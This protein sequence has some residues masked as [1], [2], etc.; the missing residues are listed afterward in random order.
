[1]TWNS[2]MITGRFL[3][4]IFL[5]QEGDLDIFLL[6][7]NR[8]MLQRKKGV[9]SVVLAKKRKRQTSFIVQNII[10]CHTHTKKNVMIEYALGIINFVVSV[11]D[12]INSHSFSTHRNFC[13]N[14]HSDCSLNIHRNTF[15][16]I[17]WKLHK[18][19]VIMNFNKSTNNMIIIT[20]PYESSDGNEYAFGSKT[21]KN[22]KTKSR[23]L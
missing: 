16:N 15:R 18:Q 3:N 10:P 9:R 2:K 1:M 19:H 14:N 4:S 5:Q 8:Y 7:R 17:I 23:V 21:K 6:I 22:Y 11:Y 20:F 12:F 13:R